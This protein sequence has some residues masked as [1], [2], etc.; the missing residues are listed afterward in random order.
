LYPDEKPRFSKVL[1]GTVRG[2]LSAI[3]TSNRASSQS[4]S[5]SIGSTSGIVNAGL[6][7]GI[8][9]GAIVGVFSAHALDTKTRNIPAAAKRYDRKGLG[10]FGSFILTSICCKAITSLMAE[11]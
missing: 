5:E 7:G 8:I 2:V 3:R 1:S 11:F 4:V 10:V 6:V 9:V